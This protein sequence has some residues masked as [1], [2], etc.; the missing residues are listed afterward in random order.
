MVYTNVA[1]STNYELP[2]EHL[3]RESNGHVARIAEPKSWIDT[4]PMYFD[5]ER[6]PNGTFAFREKDYAL[7]MK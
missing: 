2:L 6:F 5:I 1:K 7:K 3:T 4:S